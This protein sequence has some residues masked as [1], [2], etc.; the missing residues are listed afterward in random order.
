MD[1]NNVD[2][3]QWPEEI[4]EAYESLEVPSLYSVIKDYEKL[5][6]EIRLQHREIKTLNHSISEMNHQ[7]GCIEE[8]LVSKE[9]ETSERE[10]LQ[11]S[12]IEGTLMTLVPVCASIAEPDNVQRKPRSCGSNPLISISARI[13][14]SK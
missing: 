1:D 8:L 4:R 7:L 10:T 2:I 12:D 6:V 9:G 3:E 11:I 14:S 13:A 5:S